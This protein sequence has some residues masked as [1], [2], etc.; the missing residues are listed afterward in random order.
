MEYIPAWHAAKVGMRYPA[1][2]VHT[3]LGGLHLHLD[4]TLVAPGRH[5]MLA[6]TLW[7]RWTV[8]P[9][10]AHSL[11]VNDLITVVLIRLPEVEGLEN[12]SVSLPADSAWLTWN[13]ETVRRLAQHIRETHEFGLLPILADAL[14]DAGCND[15]AL[16]SHCREPQP[17]AAWS[18]AVEL[19]ATQTDFR[20]AT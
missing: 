12:L 11:Q 1:R 6:A 8:A 20:T 4:L 14:E 7:D 2:V 17:E 9:E 10:L 5:P 3:W 18:W 13:D 16:L 15:V 19:L